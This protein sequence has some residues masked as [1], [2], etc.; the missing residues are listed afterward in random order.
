VTDLTIMTQSYHCYDDD[1]NKTLFSSMFHR[2]TMVRRW[3]ILENKKF[4]DFWSCL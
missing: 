3:N 2:L 4:R 1:V